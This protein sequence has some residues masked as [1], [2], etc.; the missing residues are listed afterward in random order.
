MSE[1]IVKMYHFPWPEDVVFKLLIL[2]QNQDIQLT[3]IDHKEKYSIFTFD[4]ME[5]ENILYFCLK[6]NN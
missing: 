5:P 2:V 3:T 4:N 1:R 6:K